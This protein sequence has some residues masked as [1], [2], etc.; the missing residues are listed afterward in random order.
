[1]TYTESDLVLPS[2]REMEHR[3]DDGISTAELITV[4]RDTLAPKGSDL[5][6]L[7][8]R[9]DDRFSQ[10]VRNL[11]SHDRF[12]R[13]H[14][15]VFRD[16]KYFITAL[17]I[18]YLIKHNGVD[19]SLRNQGFSEIQKKLAI[20]ANIEHV[21]IEEGQQIG[22]N[23]KTRKRSGILR[24]QALKHYSDANG[25]IICRGCGFEG[26]AFYGEQG[27]ALIDMHHTEPISTTEPNIRVAL[28]EAISK[29]APLCPNCH[30]LV[31]KA[32]EGLT[33]ID[34]LNILTGYSFPI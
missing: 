4:L 32:N 18:N 15:A 25:R 7:A 5:T 16:R 19:I 3:G 11:K 1:M 34:E 33:S 27:D 22:A 8:G 12:T 30:R 24:R 2:L 29:I 21:F 9:Q 28:R 17:G 26:N 6:L 14:L 13:E 31:H 10:K 23:Q 20:Q